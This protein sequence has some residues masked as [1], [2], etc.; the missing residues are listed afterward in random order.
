MHEI[1]PKMTLC[2][3]SMLPSNSIHL[4]AVFRY[5]VVIKAV[6]SRGES[7][8][9]QSDKVSVD[10][11]KVVGVLRLQNYKELYR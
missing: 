2:K 4:L 11:L 1:L 5:N 6:S 8:K 10:T 9:K 3:V 7:T